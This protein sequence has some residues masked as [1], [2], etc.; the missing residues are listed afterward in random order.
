MEQ[1]L[2]DFILVAAVLG[3]KLR[4]SAFGAYPFPADT[5]TERKL[6]TDLPVMFLAFRHC[7]YPPDFIMIFSRGCLFRILF[8]GKVL[9]ERLPAAVIAITPISAVSFK[10]VMSAAP[11]ALFRHFPFLIRHRDVVGRPRVL[12]FFNL[13]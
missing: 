11:G 12:R 4:R 13:V 7:C 6:L 10:D 5:Q 9:V 2:R 3:C 8:V 1:G